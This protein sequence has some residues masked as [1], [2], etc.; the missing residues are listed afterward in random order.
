[1]AFTQRTHIEIVGLGDRMKGISKNGG[2]PYDFQTV[3]FLYPSKYIAGMAAGTST[4]QGE[5]LDA[6]SEPLRVGVTYDAFIETGK[7]GY[8]KLVGII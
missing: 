7:G 1:M 5:Q 4:V 6:L 2:K 3:A 8:V